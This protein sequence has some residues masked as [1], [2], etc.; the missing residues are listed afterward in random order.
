[1]KSSKIGWLADRE[2]FGG[3][4]TQVPG[5]DGLFSPR[6]SS[7]GRYIAALSLDQRWLLLYDVTTHAWQTLATTSVA[8]ALRLG[9][10]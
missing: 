9:G 5:S 3:G 10:S 4:I 8:D 1:V 6:W 2:E 7:D